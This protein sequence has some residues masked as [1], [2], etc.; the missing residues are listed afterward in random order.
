[1]S[2]NFEFPET[3]TYGKLE[4]EAVGAVFA[5]TQNTHGSPGI[6]THSGLA[7]FKLY[8]ET[9][10]A[11]YLDLLTDITHA[12]PQCLAHPQRKMPGVK[13]GWINERIDKL[14]LEIKNPTE[15]DANLKVF[16][17][18]IEM[19]KQKIGPNFLLHAN[20]VKVP[21]LDSVRLTFFKP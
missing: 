5:N 3:S 6:C 20:N 7:L 12:I 2:Y 11:F 13:D 17:E 1:M 21:A 10:D 4:I 14:V 19:L 9:G 16:E 8:R 15:M 18:K